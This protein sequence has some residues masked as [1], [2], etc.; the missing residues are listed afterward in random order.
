MDIIRQMLIFLLSMLPFA[1]GTFFPFTSWRTPSFGPQRSYGYRSQ[2]SSPNNNLIPI[3]SPILGL[4]VLVPR[5]LLNLFNVRPPFGQEPNYPR[6]NSFN[7]FNIN[8]FTS[9]PNYPHEHRPN[10]FPQPFTPNYFPQ[11]YAPP[12]YSPHTPFDAGSFINFMR[13]LYPDMIYRP[14]PRYPNVFAIRLPPNHTHSPDSQSS[15]PPEFDQ[16]PSRFFPEENPPN[17]NEFLEPPPNVSHTH[18]PPYNQPQHNQQP[19]NHL[20]IIR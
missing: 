13:A 11:N 8:P 2:R 3:Q 1:T 20:I 4:R 15:P 19:Q 9:H 5:D 17:V 6:P 12:N 14:D 18:S 16:E 10:G 7:P